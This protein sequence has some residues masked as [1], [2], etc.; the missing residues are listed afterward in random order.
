MVTLLFAV[1]TVAGSWVAWRRNPMYSR[2][3]TLY[4]LSAVS[5]SIAAAV[6]IFIAIIHFTENRSKE[7]QMTAVFSFVFLA[8]IGMI[9]IIV[10]VVN[11]K[12]QA[13]PKGTRLATL[14]RR[15][16]IPWL[17]RALWTLVV[18][19]I[20]AIIPWPG[21]GFNWIQFVALFIGA[22]VL[23]LGG[24]MLAAGYIGGR[25]LDRALTAVEA[26]AWIHWTYTPAEWSSWI[27]VQV[28]RC[29]V[30]IKP[31]DR[32]KQTRAVLIL[33]AIILGSCFFAFRDDRWVGLGI[34]LG[35]CATL[36]A[37]LLL[38]SRS[39]KTAPARLRRKL[40]AAETAAWIA[41]DGLYAGGEYNPWL[42][43]G[44]FLIEASLDE[45]APRSL[46]F[47]F[48]KIQ[49][50]AG[51]SSTSIVAQAVLIPAALDAAQLNQQL[52]ALQPQ[53][54]SIATTAKVRIA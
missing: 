17:K 30:E 41:P 50:S 7:I 26:N 31:V 28:A 4:Y 27:D 46:L 32:K 11:P 39:E 42:S 35:M 43:T 47:N 45:R 22:W 36:A 44:V 15:R 21:T 14:H 10:T 2:S 29:Q 13:I 20:L 37:I 16:L 38:A 1:L 52:A 53:L 54:D 8:T 3:R 33:A 6:C 5:L 24:I 9:W 18:L 19:G 34:A 23:G 49:P 25:N 51:A 40:T 12:T 48:E